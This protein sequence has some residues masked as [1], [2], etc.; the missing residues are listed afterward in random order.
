MWLYEAA[1]SDPSCLVHLGQY[2]VHRLATCYYTTTTTIR[3]IITAEWDLKSLTCLAFEA[4]GH[5][6]LNMHHI[7]VWKK[8]LW[9]LSLLHLDAM[10]TKWKLRFIHT[11][12]SHGTEPEQKVQRI[13]N[14][15]RGGCRE[16]NDSPVLKPIHCFLYSKRFRIPIPKFSARISQRSL[17]FQE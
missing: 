3:V 15:K 13:T 5:G 12:C 2:C 16:T 9:I 10:L 14:P 7:M 17:C 8:L 1:E 6:F 11:E 4:S